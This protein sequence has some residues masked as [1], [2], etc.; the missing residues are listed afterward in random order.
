M[1]KH[2]CIDIETLS[3]DPRA[4]VISIGACVFDNTGI[5][6][7]FK[8]NIKPDSAKKFGM[9][10]S[11]DTVDW[12]AK[13][14]PAAQK[15]ALER[16]VMADFGLQQFV[17]WFN[18]HK[19]DFVW[20][21]GTMFDIVIMEHA[22]KCVAVDIPWKYWMIN[23]C[24]TLFNMFGINTKDLHATASSEHHDALDDCRVQANAVIAILNSMGWGEADSVIAF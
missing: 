8:V 21:H 12:W 4:A 10:I 19:P 5:K 7:T 3:Q 18:T 16:N 2:C 17:E 15:A 11:K 23:D 13:Q 24:R 22:L 20:A 14:S 6:H 9:I 1:K